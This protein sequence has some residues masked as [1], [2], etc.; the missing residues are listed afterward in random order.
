MAPL[1]DVT[2]PRP[3]A[4]PASAGDPRVLLLRHRLDGR[5]G[6]LQVDVPELNRDLAATKSHVA[7]LTDQVSDA[8]EHLPDPNSRGPIA[9][10][11]DAL[12]GT[13]EPSGKA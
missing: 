5:L 10:A 8:A 11:R 6:A 4:D 1:L 9:R 3:P 13:P 12:A 2:T 7:Q